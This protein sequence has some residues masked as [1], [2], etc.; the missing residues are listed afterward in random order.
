MQKTFKVLMFD[1]N[2]KLMTEKECIK[3]L[4]DDLKLAKEKE[5]C[6]IECTVEQ[7]LIVQRNLNEFEGLIGKVEACFETEQLEDGFVCALWID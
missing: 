7:L 4:K 5:K 2:K 3:E 6:Y 1:D